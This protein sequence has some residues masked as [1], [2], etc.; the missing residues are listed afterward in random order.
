[1]NEYLHW[2]AL[3]KKEKKKGNNVFLISIFD[4]FYSKLYLFKKVKCLKIQET[5]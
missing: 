4:F 2:L 3:Q 1:M 5:K